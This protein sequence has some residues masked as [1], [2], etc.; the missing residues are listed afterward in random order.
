MHRS[1]V[2]P[3]TLPSTPCALRRVW[4]WPCHRVQRTVV[5]VLGLLFASLLFTVTFPASVAAIATSGS[6]A[7]VLQ[8]SAPCSPLGDVSGDGMITAEDASIVNDILSSVRVPTEAHV[9]EAD[10]NNDGKI[11]AT[12]SAEIVAYLQGNPSAFSGCI[13]YAPVL[14]RAERDARRLTDL[15]VIK[16]VLARYAHDTGTLPTYLPIGTPSSD[17]SWKSNSASGDFRKKLRPYLY[18][19]P[20]DPLNSQLENFRYVYATIP[21][22]DFAWGTCAGKTILFATRVETSAAGHEE[23]AV[24]DG[25][26]HFTLII[27][28]PKIAFQNDFF[29]SAFLSLWR[30]FSPERAPQ[31][32]F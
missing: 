32:I 21:S 23:C 8:R 26:N 19:L 16:K 31:E 29:A 6:T 9:F 5:K 30:L 2:L 1:Y 12:D 25:Q 17:M 11:T 3:S 28:P 7:V 27:P 24:S 14:A 15:A 4:V 20:V 10:V 13:P 18:T 22:S